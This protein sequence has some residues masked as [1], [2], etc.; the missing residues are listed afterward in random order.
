MGRT[1]TTIEGLVMACSSCGAKNRILL[2]RL[3]DGP[4]CGKCGKS[5]PHPTEPL[6][7][8]DDSFEEVLSRSALPVVVDFWAA[9]CGPC[10]TFA[11]VFLKFA[12][13]NAG[14][15]LAVKVNVDHAKQVAARR[16]IQSIP[17]TALYVAGR[18]VS[19]EVGNLTLD[20]LTR[21]AKV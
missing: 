20:A 5:V 1:K 10:K 14:R 21:M 3:A 16:G 17:T 19:R 15:V 7:L 12:R 11:P 8:D 2:E 18:E 13:A 4:K 9:W 6:N